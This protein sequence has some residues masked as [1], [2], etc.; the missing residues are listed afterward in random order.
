VLLGVVRADY[1]LDP[2]AER[3]RH[4]VVDLLGHRGAEGDALVGPPAVDLGV[5]RAQ[6]GDEGGE[7]AVV[8]VAAG[9]VAQRTDRGTGRS[10]P[11]S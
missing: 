2:E 7:A 3:A 9:L 1:G 8:G 5:G 10:R 4:G 6:V 11:S